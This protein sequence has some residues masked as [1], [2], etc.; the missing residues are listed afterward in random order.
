[1][2]G[3]VLAI[4]LHRVRL[5]RDWAEAGTGVVDRAL[6]PELLADVEAG[7][8]VGGRW[9]LDRARGVATLTSPSPKLARHE[10]PLRPMLGTIAVAPARGEAFRTQDSGP[11]G[12]NMDYNALREGTTVY[13]TVNVPGALLTIGDGHAAQ[14]D[15]ELTGD[16]LETSMDVEFSVSLVRGQPP[17]G[18]RAEDAD[19]LMS[20]G[21]A[22]TLDEALK[23]ATSD[24]MAWLGQAR[25]LGRGEVAA[26][27]G[28]AMEYQVADV[29]GRQVSVVAKLPKK[30]LAR[31][32]G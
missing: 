24:L 29:V 27:F 2:P 18:P 8:A 9:T 5:N 25:G 4:H 20:I 10:V 13:L 7:P 32:G 31:L 15:G 6:A 3:D 22:A 30:V 1:M 14:G 19:Y 11:F 23:L 28:T 21:I 26:L 16:A 17:A 12:G